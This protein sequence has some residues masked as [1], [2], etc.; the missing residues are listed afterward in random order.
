M[1]FLISSPLSCTECCV[2]INTNLT[3]SYNAQTRLLFKSYKRNE[4]NSVCL[5][6]CLRMSK[7]LCAR[8]FN[9]ISSLLFAVN[10]PFSSHWVSV[11][12]LRRAGAILDIRCTPKTPVTFNC[13][14]LPTFFRTQNN[15][16]ES[17]LNICIINRMRLIII[18]IIGNKKKWLHTSEQQ[19]MAGEWRQNESSLQTY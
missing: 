4:K 13:A 10:M 17:T 15:K 9:L 8:I 3:R 5:T 18:I 16:N 7:M 11:C 1:P 19:R 6:H 14:R 2:C 12:S